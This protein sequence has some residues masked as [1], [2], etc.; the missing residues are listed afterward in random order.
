MS[1]NPSH[2][3]RL[4]LLLILTAALGVFASSFESSLKQ[5]N[6]DQVLYDNTGEIK[7]E[8]MEIHKEI[9]VS[10]LAGVVRKLL[11]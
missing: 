3:S 9:C 4:S 2:Y 11:Q 7:L 10:F 1:R 8:S 6:I 5:S